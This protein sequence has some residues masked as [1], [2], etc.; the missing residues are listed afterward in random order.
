MI[1]CL[2]RAGSLEETAVRLSNALS[3]QSKRLTAFGAHERAEPA[4]AIR[5][6]RIHAFE[7]RHAFETRHAF[8]SRSV[9][10]LRMLG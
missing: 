9:S 6:A 10:V 2:V 4:R 1:A 3:W 8:E 7:S 5:A